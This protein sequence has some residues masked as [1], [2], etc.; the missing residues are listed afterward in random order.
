M[1]QN[2]QN[3]KKPVHTP[4]EESIGLGNTYNSFKE[5]EGKGPKVS[6]SMISDYKP[7]PA[8]LSYRS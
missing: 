3:Q 8:L 5:N 7:K 1:L 6:M 2:F 4:T